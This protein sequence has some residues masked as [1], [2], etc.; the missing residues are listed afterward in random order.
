MGYDQHDSH[1]LAA[2]VLDFLHEDTNEVKKKPY[3]E[4]E[5][6]SAYAADEDGAR[7]LL[8]CSFGR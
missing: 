6:V 1:E 2:A 5:E 7:Q 4:K 8:G 3:I